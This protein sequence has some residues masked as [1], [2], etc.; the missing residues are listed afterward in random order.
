MNYYYKVIMKRIL[1]PA[2]I[3][4]TGMVAAMVYAGTDPVIVTPIGAGTGTSSFIQMND[5]FTGDWQQYG[6]TFTNLQA[7]LF[8]QLFLVILTLIPAVFLLHYILIGAKHFDHEGEDVYFFSSTTRLIHWVAAVS[9]SLL[10][11]TGLMIIFGKLLGGGTLIM[12][13]RI[14]HIASALVFAVAAVFMF[15]I[16]LKD[17][18]PMPYD[19]AWLFIMG[20]YLSKKKKPIPAGKFNAGQKMWFWLA[21]VGGL[22]MAY[23]GWYLYT[24]Q[25]TTDQLRILAIIH[26][27]LGAAMIAMF[28]VHL[29][30]SMFAIKGA[31]TSMITGYKPR[32]EVE[33]LHSRYKI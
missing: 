25:V 14:V 11:V 3:A 7:G 9:F 28:L 32:E 26:N 18:L 29:Y 10:V 31:L 17:M 5:A 8:D 12:G 22:V 30:M 1:I 27:F 2:C 23:T 6:Q 20:G 33:I 4:A 16:W 19:I 13:G 21:T 24:F 15:L